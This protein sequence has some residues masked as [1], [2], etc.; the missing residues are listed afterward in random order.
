MEV[1][2]ISAAVDTQYVKEIKEEY[3]GY[4]NQTIKKMVTQICTWYVITTKENLA[5]KYPFLATWSN[6]TEAHT[7]TFARQLDRHQ[8]S[9]KYHGITITSDNTVDHFVDQMY[10]YVLSEKKT[11][12]NWEETADNLW[13]ATHP[14]FTWKFKKERCKLKR[15][16]YQQNF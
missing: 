15:E 1:E 11:L 8:V 10:A 12:D 2:A 7:T 4:K 6:T 5:T 9:Y 3:L 14:H 16:K 13:G